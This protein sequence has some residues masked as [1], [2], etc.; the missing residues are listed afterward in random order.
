MLD[1]LAVLLGSPSKGFFWFNLPAL[2]GVAGLVVLWRRDRALAAAIG[3]VVAARF[4]F[5]AVWFQ[6]GGGVSWGPRFLF[7]VVPLMIVAAAGLLEETMVKY[8]RGLRSAVVGGATLAAIV[9]VAVAAV[10]IWVPYEQVVNEQ[11]NT[12]AAADRSSRIHA[13]SWDVADSH[14]VQSFHLLDEARPFPLRHWRGGPSLIG[15]TATGMAMVLGA[16]AVRVSAE[17]RP[18]S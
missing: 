2:L 1:G 13:Y 11:V 3:V 15:L 5:Y 17:S 16:A 12:G 10:S 18:I 4:V 9:G 6:S 8:P 7:P 14:I